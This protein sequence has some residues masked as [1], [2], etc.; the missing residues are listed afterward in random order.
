MNSRSGTAPLPPAT[1][2][3]VSIKAYA[4]WI[5]GLMQ[6]LSRF[7]QVL[8]DMGNIETYRADVGGKGE[9][10]AAQ[11]FD[12]LLV[13]AIR[14]GEVITSFRE[15]VSAMRQEHGEPVVPGGPPSVV[16]GPWSTRGQAG[17]ELTFNPTVR[18]SVTNPAGDFCGLL[19]DTP[20]AIVLIIAYDRGKGRYLPT[21]DLSVMKTAP[22]AAVLRAALV[23]VP[24][25]TGRGEMAL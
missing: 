5:D 18:S 21:A 24:A 13:A 3:D 7:S 1:L 10:D 11:E 23:P 9:A 17:M 25:R 8:S 12:D 22:L 2:G 20:E 14:T 4:Q 16:I 19:W 6:N 15:W